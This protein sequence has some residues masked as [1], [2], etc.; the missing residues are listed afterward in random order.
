MAL[1]RVLISLAAV[2]LASTAAARPRL[3]PSQERRLAAYDVLVFSDA[4]QGGV[5]K[6]KAISIMDATP[7]EVFRVATDYARWKEYLPR[8]RESVVLERSPTGALVELMAELP[9]PAGRSRVQVRHVH[10]KLDGERY[11]IRFSLVRGDMKQY[12]GSLFIEPWARD[13]ATL[14]YELVAEPDVFAPNAIINRSIR[15]S[16]SGFVH[17]L[18]QR[19]NDLH[20]VGLLH[21]LQDPIRRAPPAPPAPTEAKLSR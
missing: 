11:R 9:W 20:R 6:G 12:L 16:V 5:E 13:K 17:A 18:R 8:V 15:R 14:T 3:A 21:P 1:L 7:E 10:E 2:S 4:Y 19:L